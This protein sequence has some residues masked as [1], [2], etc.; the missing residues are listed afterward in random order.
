M[1]Y[2]IFDKVVKV[3]FYLEESFK[4]AGDAVVNVDHEEETFPELDLGKALEAMV[5][6]LNQ[7]IVDSL[8]LLLLL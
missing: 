6:R 2:D 4:T 7:F 5:R 1:S 8:L 3:Q